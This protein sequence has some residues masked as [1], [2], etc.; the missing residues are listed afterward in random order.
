MLLRL[1]K[2]NRPSGLAFILFLILLLLVKTALAPAETESIQAMPLYTLLFGRLQAM[3]WLA[4]AAGMLVTAFMLVLVVRMNVIHFLLEDRTFMPATFFL[5][6]S[7]SW[8]QALQLNPILISTPFLLMAILT[9]I[10]GDEHRADPLALFNASLLLAAGSLFYLKILWFMPV[11]WLTALLI[12]PLKWRGILNPLAVLLLLAL[13]MFTWYWVFRDDASQ[14]TALLRSNLRIERQP[15]PGFAPSDLVM[16]SFLGLL[17]VISSIHLLSRYPFRKIIIRKLYRVFFIMYVYSLMVYLLISG[18]RGEI[19]V[20][21]ALPLA[22]L[23]SNF[24]YRK[25]SHW[26]QELLMWTWL[27]LVIYVNIEPVIFGS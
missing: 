11:F 7:A 1:I 21:L 18:Y 9:L 23:F 3:P 19:M 5:L 17:I 13:F 2:N 26:M 4:A 25:K 16:L 27:L 10:R 20:I 14:F 22:Y 12:R 8:P 24:F 15:F 6:I